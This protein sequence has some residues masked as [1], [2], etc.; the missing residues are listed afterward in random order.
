MRGYHSSI[1]TAMKV[2]T[3]TDLL[4][5]DEGERLKVYSDTKGIPT[6]GVGRNI[7]DKGLSLKESRFLLSN[8]VDEI[9]Q[10]CS[11]WPWFA[12]LPPARQFVL[13][14]MRFIFGTGFSLQWPIFISQVAGGQWEKAAANLERSVW[15]SQA[16]HRVER[17]AKMLRTGECLERSEW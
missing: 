17:F 16:S 3:I 1:G 8:D 4:I 10:D 2:E 6:I 15:H 11:K 12:A 14:S 5:M 7:R 13:L 9:T